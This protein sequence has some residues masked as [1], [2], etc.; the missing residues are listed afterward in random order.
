MAGTV[1]VLIAELLQLERKQCELLNCHKAYI[2]G[3][4]VIDI[5]ANHRQV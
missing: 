2:Y 3:M 5:F 1:V 4:D